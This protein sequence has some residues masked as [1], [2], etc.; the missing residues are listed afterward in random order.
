MRL[1]NADEML[2]DEN[3]AYM[4]AQIKLSRSGKNLTYKVNEVVHKKIQMLI[5]DTPT[6][7]LPQLYRKEDVIKVIAENVGRMHGTPTKA[8]EGVAEMWLRDIPV[9]GVNDEVKESD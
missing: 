3:E 8:M 4:N 5:M 1:I 2:A 7:E 6:V 9:F